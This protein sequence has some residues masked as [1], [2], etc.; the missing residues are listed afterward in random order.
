MKE[1]FLQFTEE[2]AIRALKFFLMAYLVGI[3][4]SLASNKNSSS[5]LFSS[6]HNSKLLLKEEL[7]NPILEECYNCFTWD[8]ELFF[9]DKKALS[10]YLQES[11]LEEKGTR[12]N[13]PSDICE[14]LLPIT[15]PEFHGDVISMN[16]ASQLL[17]FFLYRSDITFE[18]YEDGCYARSAVMRD[19]LEKIG[20]K[21]QSIFI[22][23]DNGRRLEAETNFDLA[24]WRWHVAPLVKIRDVDGKI[25][26]LVI[27]PSISSEPIS[28]NE[29]AS[30]MGHDYCPQKFSN[31]DFLSRDNT[32]GYYID[33]KD[34][35]YEIDLG[36]TGLFKREFV[37]LS[38]TEKAKEA[39]KF[40]SEEKVISKTKER[41]RVFPRYDSINRSLILLD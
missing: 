40:M 38:Q 15:K 27:D 30:L 14:T 1:L 34:I 33:T 2:K 36:W 17:R 18:Y 12:N 11:C 16:L 39:I 6:N 37:Y 29:W 21:S 35:I 3:N 7:T 32:C 41:M 28:V 5:V 8:G 20:I 25:K 13:L 4:F 26:K 23:A 10:I 9:K 19:V 31:S 24:D 22:K